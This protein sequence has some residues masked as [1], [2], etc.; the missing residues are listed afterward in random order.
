MVKKSLFTK[1]AVAYMVIISFSFI[2]LAGFLSFWFKSYYLQQDTQRL[3]T[4]K[5]LI[6]GII[7]NYIYKSIDDEDMSSSLNF[8]GKAIS[9]DII[10]TDS[11][12]VVFGVSNPEHEK[13]IRKNLAGTNE[14]S[15]SRK[16][17]EDDVVKTIRDSIYGQ[18]VLIDHE[19]QY[20]ENNLQIATTYICI[21][22][23]KSLEPLKRVYQIIWISAVYV[24]IFS[25]I[26][27]Y[28][29][30][31]RMI[32]NPLADINSVAKKIAKGEVEKRVHIKSDDEIGELAVS[33]NSMADSLE[34]IDVNRRQFI[35]N[36]SHEI[37]TPITT[38]KG[39]VGGILD[40]I[41][42]E[43]K[44]D[45]YLNMVYDETKSLTR[46]VND[47]LDLSALE[48][49][50]FN[51][52]IEEID[53][54][55][56][57][58]IVVLRFENKITGKGLNVS[59]SF[60]GEKVITLGDRDRVMQVCTNL[61]DNAIKYSDEAGT[62]SVKTKIKGRKVHV[63]FSNTCDESVDVTELKKIW[64]RF[65]RIDKARTSRESSGLGLS[66]VRGIISQM[67]EDIWVDKINNTVEFTFTLKRVKKYTR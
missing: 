51:Q 10:V 29:F 53:I 63:S 13:F 56:I 57:I 11:S 33:F 40:G 48:S 58:R 8:L 36:V 62:I 14:H 24:L 5:A 42:P 45:H 50:K 44:M 25:T 9:A 12:G 46:L 34:K 38:I 15:K 23:N 21:P 52:V 59:V 39:F 19:P 37:R 41:I 6:E 1:M 30:S 64:Q 35:S 3:S 7:H 65:Y 22:Q 61:L 27:I 31:Q 17:I 43:D 26:G 32:I 2:V 20:D 67:G 16:E 49:G 18:D 66:I 60:E 55:E 28:I 47:L 54:N 4:Q